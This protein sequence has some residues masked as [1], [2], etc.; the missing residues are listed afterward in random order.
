MLPDLVES[1]FDILNPVQ[2]SAAGMDPRKLKEQFGDK[3]TFWGGGVDTQKT[4]PFGSAEQV[5]KEVR[6]RIG[7][8][9][10]GGD[11]SSTRSTTSRPACL[12]RICWRC[13]KK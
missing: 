1:G 8:F 12:R 10:K 9:G 2:C 4:L 3:V 11:S 6:E 13:T 5:R 7:V